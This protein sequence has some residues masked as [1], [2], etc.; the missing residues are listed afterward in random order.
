MFDKDHLVSCAG[1]VPVTTLADQTGLRRLLGGGQ[2]GAQAGYRGGGHMCGGG[3]VSMTSTVH[4]G[5]MTPMFDG[6]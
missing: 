5:G 3:T 1:L 2:P 4:R 6:V